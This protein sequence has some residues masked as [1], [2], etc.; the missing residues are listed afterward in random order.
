MRKKFLIGIIF[1]VFASIVHAHAVGQSLEKK[2]G[3]YVVDIGYDS[4]DPNIVAGEPVRFDFLLWNEDRTE[5]PEFTDVWVRLAPNTPGV[6][7]AGDIFQP[8]YGPTG[9]NYVFPH[10][11]NYEL[12]VRFQKKGDTLAEAAFPLVVTKGGNERFSKNSMRDLAFAFVGGISIG[13]VIL[14]FFKKKK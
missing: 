1:F 9:I 3:N 2:V 14:L 7:F 13:F 6:T 4:L 5:V 12:V 10:G 11:G 8:Q